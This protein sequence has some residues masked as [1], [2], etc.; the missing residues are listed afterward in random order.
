MIYVKEGFDASAG[1]TVKAKEKKK[2]VGCEG[3]TQFSYCGLETSK[4]LPSPTR[5]SR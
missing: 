4:P 1:A 3:G 5:F 2:N